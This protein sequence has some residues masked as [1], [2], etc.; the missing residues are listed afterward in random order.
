MKKIIFICL[1]SFCFSALSSQVYADATKKQTTKKP[2]KKHSH[3]RKKVVVTDIT[4]KGEITNEPADEPLNEMS[5]SSITSFQENW[6]KA[7]TDPEEV[8]RAEEAKKAKEE[9]QK[10]LE[11]KLDKICPRSMPFQEWGMC[12]YYNSP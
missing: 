3:R 5:R 8:K 1:V 11:E 10:E 12:R 4:V 9:K 6:N 2:I 7:H